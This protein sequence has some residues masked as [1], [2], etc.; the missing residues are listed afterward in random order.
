MMSQ[1]KDQAA[2]HL[3]TPMNSAHIIIDY[4]PV[5]VTSVAS[6]DGRAL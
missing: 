3:L 4:Q 1:P 6:M 5:Q 2:D